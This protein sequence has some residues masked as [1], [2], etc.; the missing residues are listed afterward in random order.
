MSIRT[1][2]SSTRIG[3]ATIVAALIAS[4]FAFAAPAGANLDA[5]SVTRYA[6]SDRYETAALAALDT[7][8]GLGPQYDIVLASG[9]N[10]PDGLGAAYLAGVAEAPVLLTARAALPASTANAIGALGGADESLV[11]VH[12]VGG[13]AAVSENV[14]TQLTNLGYKVNA[15]GGANR[16]ETAA[17]VAAAGNLIGGVGEF[18]GLRTAIV[19]TGEAFPDALAAG[20]FSYAGE[21]GDNP[22]PIVLTTSNSLS[23]SADT[24]LTNLNIEQAVIVGG[25]AAVSAAVETAIEAKGIDTVRVS[26]ANRFGTA[27]ALANLLLDESIEGGADWD[28]DGFVLA[29][30][31]N[32]PDALSASQVAGAY[33]FPIILSGSIPTDTCNALGAFGQYMDDLVVMGGTA[34]ISEADVTA[35]LG[36]S[37]DQAPTA[38]ITALDGRSSFTVQYSTTVIGSDDID[39]YRVNN[40]T[41][42]ISGITPGPAGSNLVTVTVSTPL[43]PNDTITVNPA[44]EPASTKVRTAGGGLVAQTNFTIAK[45]NTRPAVAL[46]RFFDGV[47]IGWIFTTEAVNSSYTAGD[48]TVD[49]ANTAAPA[50]L[51]TAPT[52]GWYVTLA[53]PEGGD[54]VQIAEGTFVDVATEPNE[55]PAYSTQVTTDNTKPTL[56]SATHTLSQHY[57]TPGD[58][59]TA[60]LA[61]LDVDGLVI[62]A[63][64]TG[65]AS[66]HLGNAWTFEAVDTNN[67]AVTVQ[68]NA[69]TKVIRVGFTDPEAIPTA[70]LV[71]A[72]ANNPTFNANFYTVVDG[73]GTTVDADLYDGDD[74]A[75]GISNVRVLTQWSEQIR[76]A[77]FGSSLSGAALV[78]AQ[79]ASVNPGVDAAAPFTG[80]WV[81][82]Y[83]VTADSQISTQIVPPAGSILDLAGN[84]NNATAA[85]ITAG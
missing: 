7:F 11:T 38:T 68:V 22:L 50:P 84:T 3:V 25:T 33:G 54:S 85:N 79:T 81:L 43:A 23:S 63:R 9:E 34:A 72:L 46:A 24:T 75:G 40:S 30:G 14:R 66:G 15:I 21:D 12:I 52:T 41:A 28:I 74:L 56:A 18:Q 44:A 67:T 1:Q 10:F 53:A 17:N 61:S 55:N 70:D 57:T 78:P 42:T 47:T 19:V 45:D 29:N 36:C 76:P 2:R 35:A 13:T 39:N 77:A 59:T 71:I 32:F 31:T 83:T 26:G 49:G 80:G 16:Y 62:Y 4:I 82:V 20:A 73:A 27:A 58:P 60:A 6:G 37:T 51:G 64:A 8:Q 69:T 65:A 5:D 48:I